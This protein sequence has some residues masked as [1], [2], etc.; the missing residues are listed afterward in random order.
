MAPNNSHPSDQ[1]QPLLAPPSTTATTPPSEQ[2]P[3][4]QEVLT[5]GIPRPQ[6]GGTPPM[7]HNAA[8]AAS[9]LGPIALLLPGRGRGMVSIQNLILSSGTFWGLNQLAWDYTGKSI[10][11]RSNEQWAKVLKPLDPLPEKAQATKLRMEAARAAREAAMPAAE[12][13][14]LE[15]ARRQKE[16]QRE[17][18]RRGALG[19]LWMGGETEGWKER[20]IEEEKKALES[21]KG[22][23]DLIIDQIWEVWNQGSKKSKE[24]AEQAKNLPSLVPA[25]LSATD[26]NK[27]NTDDDNSPKQNLDPVN[28]TTKKP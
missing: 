17:Q 6:Y 22:Y 21:G 4:G 25:G 14:A 11:Q 3:D 1:P 12:R 2:P 9:V 13:A 16:E 27:Y 24:Q 5:G 19:R 28:D 26:G 20:R 8:I 18:E 7:L 15:E 10:Y 23:A